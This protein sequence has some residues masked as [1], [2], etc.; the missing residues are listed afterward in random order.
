MDDFQ[1]Q[2]ASPA[3]PGLA[4]KLWC[5][6]FLCLLLSMPSYAKYVGYQAQTQN[7][8]QGF[9]S[10]L[11][12]YH[13]AYFDRGPEGNHQLVGYNHNISNEG[14]FRAQ[15]TSSN[16][17][18]TFT[19]DVLSGKC[20][21]ISFAPSIPAIYPAPVP[22]EVG[23]AVPVGPIKV[24]ATVTPTMYFKAKC[25]ISGPGQAYAAVEGG[26][27]VEFEVKL[28]LNTIIFEP[29][30]GAKFSVGAGA[31][32]GV[33]YGGKWDQATLHH[34]Y[35]LASSGQ[36]VR[37]PDYVRFVFTPKVDAKLIGGVELIHDFCILEGTLK[38]AE[39]KVPLTLELGVRYTRPDLTRFNFYVS[40]DG[41]MKVGALGGALDKKIK[42]FLWTFK[43]PIIDIPYQWTWERNLFSY[44]ERGE[45]GG[46]P[47][48]WPW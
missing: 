35:V 46:Y 11:Q 44:Y 36:W 19:I 14:F 6:F 17:N 5:A 34:K 38:L 15:S 47:V 33:G 9:S 32:M 40:A 39:L 4:F 42:I 12:Q 43:F 45:D 41:T 10:T 30:F 20:G 24:S 22:S 29:Y 1:F 48:A 28:K 7:L 3:R 37:A 21:S 16:S 18:G 23:A 27:G 31:E 25:T 8:G 2:G 26:A 13:H